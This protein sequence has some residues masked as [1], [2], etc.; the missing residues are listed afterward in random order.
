MEEILDLLLLTGDKVTFFVL[1]ELCANEQGYTLL[2]RA[3]D[4]GHDVG[5]HSY[6]HS[7]FTELTREQAEAE[8][9]ATHTIINQA[10]Q[11]AG[12]RNPR[13]FRYPFGETKYADIL[14]DLGYQTVLWDVNPKDYTLEFP[15]PPST[16]EEFVLVTQVQNECLVAQKGNII[17]LHDMVYT[18]KQIL[19]FLLSYYT[20]D[21]I[22]L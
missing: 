16:D 5:N 1:G 18:A 21:T 19:P 11:E 2:V 3:L 12:R 14:A 10:Y 8:I 15:Y 17:L 4:E 9:M 13:L 7:I 20:S 22:H 6:A